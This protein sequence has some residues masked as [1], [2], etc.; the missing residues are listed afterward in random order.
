[1]DTSSP[2]VVARVKSG[3][4]VD[5]GGRFGLAVG[6]CGVLFLATFFETGLLCSAEALLFSFFCP[7]PTDSIRQDI[8][9][10]V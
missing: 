1:M 9:V 10:T 4:G 5:P 6:F 7:Q 3:A 8:I 2:V